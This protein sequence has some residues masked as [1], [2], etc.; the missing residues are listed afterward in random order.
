MAG[1]NLIPMLP[2]ILL[3]P[4]LPNFLAIKLA[5][6]KPPGEP[7]GFFRSC[8]RILLAKKL[9]TNI[10]K[11]GSP[12]VFPVLGFLLKGCPLKIHSLLR[13]LGLLKYQALFLPNRFG[14]VLP[15]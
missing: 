15:F 8:D 6:K 9:S 7:G 13:F 11:A 12:Y 1:A 5:R 10:A 14:P 3:F 4:V 2:L